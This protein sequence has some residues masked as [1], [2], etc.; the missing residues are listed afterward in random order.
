MWTNRSLTT[1]SPLL[2]RTTKEGKVLGQYI[3]RTY[4]NAKLGVL[5]QTDAL[6]EEGD[7]GLRKGIEGS[8]AEIVD[9]EKYDAV[10]SD[11]TSQ[12]QRLKNAGA[13]VIMGFA[14]PPQAASMVKTARETLGWNVLRLRKRHQL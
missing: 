8:N 4:P 9:V 6:G 5:E 13:D 12:T 7:K 14:A 1:A 11:V 10:Q 3:A 2:L